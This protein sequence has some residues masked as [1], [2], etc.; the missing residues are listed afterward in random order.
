MQ[1]RW[2]SSLTLFR[3][4]TTC[5]GGRFICCG[6]SEIIPPNDFQQVAKAMFGPRSLAMN[7]YDLPSHLPSGLNLWPVNCRAQRQLR[8]GQHRIVGCSM[9][10]NYTKISRNDSFW[11]NSL[12]DSEGFVPATSPK[13]RI[14]WIFAWMEFW[15]VGASENVDLGAPCNV[16][17]DVQRSTP[18]WHLWDKGLDD[19]G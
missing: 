5:L 14:H 3:S 12:T 10:P 9:T 16:L 2:F 7:F 17:S 18:T 11:T 8:G 19:P 4:F 13:R 6:C 15:F 1:E